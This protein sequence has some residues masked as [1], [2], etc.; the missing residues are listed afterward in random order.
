MG[1]AAAVIARARDDFK[2]GNYRWV[3]Q[4]MD[5]VVYADPANGEA[6]ALAAAALEQLGYL[7]ESAT[8]RNAYLLGA[9]ELRRGPGASLLSPG[10]SPDML[11]AMTIDLIFD[12]LGT[13]LNGPRAGTAQ[14]TVNWH[15][16]DTKESAVSTLSH[17][18]LTAVIGAEATN[19]DA[20]VTMQRA[21]FEALVLK[22][23]GIADVI[24]AGDATVV[25][26]TT[27]LTQL[28]GLFDDFETRFSIV[29]PRGNH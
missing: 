24:R 10:V 20:T 26:N 7:A 16:P 15:F 27:R 8:W 14:V 13:R 5:Q 9:Q 12:H 2:A 22:R 17:G 29:E 3:A 28:F 1:G 23:R 25:G 4:V 18:A 21:V 11:H 19:A 6:R